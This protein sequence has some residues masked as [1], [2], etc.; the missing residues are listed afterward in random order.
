ML[1]SKEKILETLTTRKTT[2]CDDCLSDLAQVFPRQQVNQ[3]CRP[4]SEAKKIERFR[5]EC[6]KCKGSKLVNRCLSRRTQP[7]PTTDRDKRV[8][9]ILFELERTLKKIKQFPEHKDLNDYILELTRQDYL[10]N[11]ITGMMHAIRKLRNDFIKKRIP[12]TD[13]EFAALEANWLAIQEWAST[14]N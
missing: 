7:T 9:D 13:A 1:T 14:H 12:L 10:P 8:N 11:R 4:L 2:L 5:G 3:I 6:D